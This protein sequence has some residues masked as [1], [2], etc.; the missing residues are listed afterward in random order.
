MDQIW[1]TKKDV[2]TSVLLSCS[3]YFMFTIKILIIRSMV[4]LRDLKLVLSS[5]LFIA[6]TQRQRTTFIILAN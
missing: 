1:I 6:L 2:N 4:N 5:I 3:D